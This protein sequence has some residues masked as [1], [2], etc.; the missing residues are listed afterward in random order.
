M[1]PSAS[2]PR[3]SRYKKFRKV[4]A[5]AYMPVFTRISWWWLAET[6]GPDRL[7][8]KTVSAD[9]TTAQEGNVHFKNKA[10]ARAITS[11]NKARKIA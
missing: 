6:C 2:I 11:Y 10:F 7:P 9:V 1:C 4:A 5:T 8:L 3:P